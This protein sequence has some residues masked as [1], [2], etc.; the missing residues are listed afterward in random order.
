MPQHSC[1]ISFRHKCAL[2]AHRRAK[3]GQPGVNNLTS[4]CQSE[5]IY[6]QFLF[7]FQRRNTKGT[8]NINK[9]GNE[10]MGKRVCMACPLSIR[11]HW[12]AIIFNAPAQHVELNP[13]QAKQKKHTSFESEHWKRIL[14]SFA[15]RHRDWLYLLFWKFMNKFHNRCARYRAT[16]IIWLVAAGTHSAIFYLLRN[17]NGIADI[18]STDIYENWIWWSG[19]YA[20]QHTISSSQQHRDQRREHPKKTKN[21]K[22]ST[23]NVIEWDKT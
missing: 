7:L 6:Q 8:N 5:I 21:I 20:E 3:Y 4:P 14:L 10:W 13:L 19:E 2:C 23:H 16:Q 18:R 12:S 17:I 9:T 11:R 15:S 22:K 1:Q